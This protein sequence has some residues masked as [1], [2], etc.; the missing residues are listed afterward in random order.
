MRSNDVFNHTVDNYYVVTFV[1]EEGS[2]KPGITAVP[3]SWWVKFQYIRQ[4][5]SV[6]SMISNITHLHQIRTDKCLT[7]FWLLRV[8]K[9][10]IL[11]QVL[12]IDYQTKLRTQHFYIFVNL[13]LKIKSA[14]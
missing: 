4:E 3:E 10:S 8:S 7:L 13:Y 14:T 9:T 1:S 2:L 12:H 11:L 5:K 6:R